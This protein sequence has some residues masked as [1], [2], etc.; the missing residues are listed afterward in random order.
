MD[1]AN[2]AG[3]GTPGRPSLGNTRTELPALVRGG[4]FS[5]YPLLRV[6]WEVTQLEGLAKCSRTPYQA[7]IEVRLDGNRLGFRGVCHCSSVWACPVCAP[8]IRGRRAAEL[9]TGLLSHLGTGGGVAFVTLTVPH[10]QG[11]RLRP[12]FDAVSVSWREVLADK[13]FRRL[14]ADLRLEC[15]RA[16]EVTHGENGW[17]PHLHGALV[18]GRQIERGEVQELRRELYRAWC[19][20]VER[21]GYEPPSWK[22]GA[23]VIQVRSGAGAVGAYITK[24]QGLAH[25]MTRLDRKAAR[26]GLAPF[27][28]LAR[29]RGAVESDGAGGERFRR[30]SRSVGLWREY[31]SATKGRRALTWSRGCR[32]LLGLTPDERS[33]SELAEPDG[34]VWGRLDRGQWR[35]LISHPSGFEDL[36]AIGL[37]LEGAEDAT[38]ASLDAAIRALRGSAPWWCTES[39]WREQAQVLRDEKALVRERERMRFEGD[40]VGLWEEEVR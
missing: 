33:D 11:D 32:V 1:Q 40:Q 6:A 10:H 20:A 37:R 16:L 24:V 14:R 25:E 4:E 29:C 23:S 17:H 28:I 18:M 7:E 26:K 38:Q 15:V 2:D 39:G 35:D 22:Y 13:S 30:D 8:R 5:G 12:L 27:G 36:A 21:R 3:F 31:E 9:A 34:G 19:S